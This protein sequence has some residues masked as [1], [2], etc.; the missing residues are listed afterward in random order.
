[1][2]ASSVENRPVQPPRGKGI[3]PALTHLEG[4]A[5]GNLR[6]WR[7]TAIYEREQDI[8]SKHVETVAR[9]LNYRGAASCCGAFGRL[10]PLTWAVRLWRTALFHLRQD[11]PASFAIGRF[12]G[13]SI[14]VRFR[15]ERRRKW[16]ASKD[17]PRNYQAAREMV[18]DLAK[19]ASTVRF[20]SASE[21]GFL[22]IKTSTKVPGAALL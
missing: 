17:A 15:V 18:L 5:R 9:F 6:R 8:R 20:R 22:R 13:F 2:A 16:L 12:D 7:A 11:R 10:P 14:G 4:Y 3:A 21:K 1:V 19:I